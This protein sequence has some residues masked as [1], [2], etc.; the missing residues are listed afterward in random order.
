LNP[1][2]VD[3]LLK[4]SIAGANLSGKGTLWRL[5]STAE[6]GQNP[7][8]SNLFLDSIPDALTLPRF[9]VNI[10]EFTTAP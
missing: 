5:A 6:N 1:T 4:L 2:N 9:S 7:G 10:Y 8:I 3:Q